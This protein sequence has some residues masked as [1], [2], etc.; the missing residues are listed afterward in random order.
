MENCLINHDS[1]G[2]FHSVQRSASAKS[3]T[4]SLITNSSVSD[5]IKDCYDF[6]AKA[7][8]VSGAGGG[9]YIIAYTMINESL[10]LLTKLWLSKRDT[11]K[12]RIDEQGAVICLRN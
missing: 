3:K 6:G 12:P 1:V 4:S 11:F 2:F 5:I 9:G 7:V 10:S 8:K